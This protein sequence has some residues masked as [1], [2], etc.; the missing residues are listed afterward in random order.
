VKVGTL[1]LHQHIVACDN[2]FAFWFTPD[3]QLRFVDTLAD[4][5]MTNWRVARGQALVALNEA[6]VLKPSDAAYK[7][8]VQF[9]MNTQLEDGS[10]YVRSRTPI[11]FQPYFESGFPFGHDQFI[12]A[13][14]TNW[15][16]MALVPLAH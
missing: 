11:P 2:R 12:S 7:R 3:D 1:G 10:W 13:A 8:E 9:L 14:A 15:A 6:R 4:G 16:T 5:L